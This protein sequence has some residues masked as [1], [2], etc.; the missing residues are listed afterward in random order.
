MLG[1]KPIYLFWLTFDD[2]EVIYGCVVVLQ[3]W[4]LS[5]KLG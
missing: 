1:V 4:C 2:E 3:Q 5:F